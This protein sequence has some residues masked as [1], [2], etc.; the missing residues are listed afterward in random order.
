VTDNGVP[1]LSAAQTFAVK[2]I[3]GPIII[4]A[5]KTTTNVTVLWRS[6]L[7]ER[8]RLQYRNNL[9]TASWAD[10]SGIDITATNFV[11]S[12]LDSG[13]STNRERYYRVLYFPAF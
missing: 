2:V 11:T 3:A 5:I 7:G 9:A 6:A 4:R 1:A 12:E 10:V 13:I 8:Y